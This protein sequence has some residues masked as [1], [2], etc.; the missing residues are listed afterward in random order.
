MLQKQNINCL[1]FI[2]FSLLHDNIKML[3]FYLKSTQIVHWNIPSLN[4]VWQSSEL[5]LKLSTYP[6][7]WACTMEPTE[8]LD[9]VL[10]WSPGELSL[11]WLISS[12]N[13]SSRYLVRPLRISIL[14]SIPSSLIQIALFIVKRRLCKK[15]AQ[16]VIF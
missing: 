15:H 11:T 9:C 10:L 7:A 16:S 12:S 5:T 1:G 3:M 2:V 8:G 6:L 14:F 13:F 4:S